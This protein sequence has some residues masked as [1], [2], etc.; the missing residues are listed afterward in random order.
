MAAT[1]Y[2]S[3]FVNPFINIGTNGIYAAIDTYSNKLYYDKGLYFQNCYN[4]IEIGVII[5]T[6]VLP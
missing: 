5:L 1:N 4:K 6:I 2:V 3:G